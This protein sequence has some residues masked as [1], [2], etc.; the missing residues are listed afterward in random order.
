MTVLKLKQTPNDNFNPD[1][2][3]REREKTEIQK[4]ETHIE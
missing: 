1:V 2:H 4:N 3:W